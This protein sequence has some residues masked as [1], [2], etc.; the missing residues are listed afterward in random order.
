M[1]HFHTRIVDH[2][3]LR[4]FSILTVSFC[5]AI[6]RSFAKCNHRQPESDLLRLLSNFNRQWHWT[7]LT[8]SP[9]PFYSFSL[10]FQSLNFFSQETDAFLCR[11][12]HSTTPPDSG[13]VPFN[14]N[15][16]LYGFDLCSFRFSI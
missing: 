1:A 15:Y 10:C 6:F 8:A 3:F 11:N 9:R 16:V 2:F 5:F 7:R 14:L 4:I 13:D 12:L